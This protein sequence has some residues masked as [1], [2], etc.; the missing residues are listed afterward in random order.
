MDIVLIGYRGSGKTSVGGALAS[1][2]DARL[3]DS[4][5]AVKARFGGREVAVVWAEEGEARFREVEGEVVSEWMDEAG[6]RTGF[7]AGDGSGSGFDSGGGSGGGSGGRVARVLSLG[8]GAVMRDATRLAIRRAAGEGRVWAVYLH[9][10]PTVLWSRIASDATSVAKRPALTAGGVAGGG[11]L[12]EIEAVL[13][14]RD[15]VYRASADAVVEVGE[16]SVEAAARAIL[17]AWER[18]G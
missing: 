10:A 15:P 5:A 12:A 11:G 3:L 16:L 18:R 1:M 4:D 13:A 14:R 17:A 8:G 7:S 6:G 9:A 2:L